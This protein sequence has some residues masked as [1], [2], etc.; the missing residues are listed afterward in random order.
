MYRIVEYHRVTT[1]H[2]ELVKLRAIT[3]KGTPK[4]ATARND[5]SRRAQVLPVVGA[6]C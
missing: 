4:A 5:H 6:R 2:H 1:S 3:G